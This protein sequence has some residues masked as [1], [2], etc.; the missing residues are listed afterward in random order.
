MTAR[1]LTTDSHTT[2]AAEAR[3]EFDVPAPRRPRHIA[4]IMDGNG[5]WAQQR[6]LP[7]LAGHK[8]GAK[9]VQ[10]TIEECAHLGISALTLFSFSTENWKRPP[11]EVDGLMQL[12]IEYL[13]RDARELTKHGIRFRQI[14]RREGLPDSVL[15][16]VEATERATA[17]CDRLDLVIALNYGSRD[18][19]TDAMRSIAEDV[20]AGTIKPEAIDAALISSRLYTKDL[21]DPDLLIRTA[22]ERRLSNYLLWQISYAEIHVSPV[23]WPDFTAEHLRDAIRDFASRERRFGGLLPE[24]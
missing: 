2:P 22:G 16:A 20:R 19:I 14:G 8:A 4:V 7:R 10:A 18:E 6:N 11:D 24:S 17:Q 23:C 3:P 13:S 1:P 5:R 21:P 12:Y 15:S 9:A